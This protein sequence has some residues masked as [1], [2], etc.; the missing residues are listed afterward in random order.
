MSV[1]QRIFNPEKYALMRAYK[2][3]FLGDDGKLNVH[4]KIIL[5]NLQMFCRARVV[6]SVFDPDT[7]FMAFKEGRREVF[8]HMVKHLRS[9]QED[10]YDIIQEVD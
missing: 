2:D 1:I 4:A 9:N 5:D 6:D 7:H 3:L 8:N 10:C